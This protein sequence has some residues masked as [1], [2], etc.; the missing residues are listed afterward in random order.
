MADTVR[1]QLQ[2]AAAPC[3][4]PLHGSAAP[5]VLARKDAGWLAYVAAHPQSS[6]SA[7]A[8]LLWPDATSAGAL[9]NLRQRI[10]RLRR[11]TGAR[12]VE[13]GEVIGLAADLA[14]LAP[15]GRAALEADLSGTD[16]GELLG[17]FEYDDLPEFAAWLATA[18]R[19]RRE[20][21]SAALAAIASDAE[22]AG[23]LA[24]ALAG[25]QRLLAHE[26]VSEHA[27][28]RLMRLHYLR[29]DNAA[30]I[31]AFE[32]CEHALRAELGVRP[33]AETIALLQLIEQ[34]AAARTGALT[35]ALQPLPVGLLRPPR[36]IGRDAALAELALAAR[37]AQVAV[38]VGEAG[39]GKTRLL[40]ELLA[41]HGE[42]A[43]HVPARPGDAAAPYAALA[44]VM[45]A[46]RTALAPAPS[47]TLL[48]MTV[49]VPP[50]APAGAA[51]L[52][53]TLE[54]SLEAA[55]ARGLQVLAIDDLHFADP[56]SVELLLAVVMSEAVPALRWILA[57]RP[58]T[59][60]ASPLQ[61]A[62]QAS[63][64][65]RYVTLEP[66]NTAQ[67][68]TFVQSLGIA[69]FDARALA[70]PLAQ[71]TGGNPLFAI[72]TLRA[73]LQAGAASGDWVL[74]KPVGL[75][76]LIGERLRR[77]SP[78]ALALGRL[79]AVA[80]P[81]FD[82][83]LAEAVLGAPALA[84]ADAWH[85]LEAAQVLRGEAFAHDL[86]H[87]ALLRATPQV[88]AA[89][90]HRQVAALLADREIAPARLAHHHRA[91]GQPH[92]AADAFARAAALATAAARPREQADLLEQCAL[93]HEAAG[94]AHAALRARIDRISA[95]LQGHGVDA[96]LAAADALA[97]AADASPLRAHVLTA[98]ALA[99]AWDGRVEPAEQ[100]ARDAL[101]A[102]APDDDTVR[103]T[104]TAILANMA[105]L[106]GDAA[107]ALALLLPWLGRIDAI[108]AAPVRRDF[109]GDLTNLLL[110]A[111]R[112]GEALAAARRH[113]ELARLTGHGGEQVA[114]L[115]N[116]SNLH[117]R[118]GDLDKAI[119]HGRAA[120]RLMPETEQASMLGPW[121]R[122]TLGFWLAGS[123]RF[124]EALAL[125]EGAVAALA[126]APVQRQLAQ[127]LLARVWITLGQTARAVAL[128]RAAP[129]M[130]PGRMRAGQWAVRA[131]VD[132]AQGLDATAAWQ[133]V[134]AH[135]TADDPTRVVAETALAGRANDADAMLALQQRAERLEYFPIA[136]EA[137]T[138][139]L[140]GLPVDG[141]ALATAAA[142]RQA[143]ASPSPF[144]YPAAQLARCA[145]AYRR[146]AC[147]ADARRCAQAALDWVHRAA[148]P[149]VPAPFVESFLHRNEVNV[150]LRAAARE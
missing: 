90:L 49:A 13:M 56:A 18:R 102:A 88:I 40:Q 71:R 73:T 2:M 21:C 118:R 37:H 104:A 98:R 83:P 148:L 16:D 89:Q 31:A 138:L 113:L 121:N 11:A 142:E 20:A 79:A 4:A 92:A 106:R 149:H 108:D 146:A 8:T 134:I 99:L 7:L 107:G 145:A 61:N 65:V 141:L 47:G 14:A 45:L 3:L 110:Q 44:R 103:L 101:D 42:R 133:E 43:I 100:A 22:S 34:S 68:E 52:R 128:V 124:D 64:M 87:D 139:R 105:G 66:W 63:P 129:E 131:C 132:E 1:W 97:D 27:H 57:Q 77:L 81:D 39:I 78:P 25:T 86:V 91:G 54:T 112:A 95:L 51:R 58:D 10:H 93:A 74:A 15:P 144:F 69:A 143:L 136:A 67:I 59:A 120:D 94:D 9:N 6:S 123:G 33:S 150:A 19:A 115:M 53:M 5:V 126:D 116:L 72:E 24:R 76:H 85:E 41:P 140:Q 130:P 46:L 70:A 127:G 80:A 96:A 29:G 84:L 36:L 109:F 114:A 147:A 23:E 125:L 50:S 12:L 17:G 32:A 38:V 135:A 75:S 119:E 62:L 26:P 55:A 30:A 117:G 122:A 137:A 28:R 111:N 82:L 48:E 60:G 35:G